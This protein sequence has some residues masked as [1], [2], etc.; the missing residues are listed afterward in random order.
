MGKK[1]IDAKVEGIFADVDLIRSKQIYELK[2][3]P[4]NAKCETLANRIEEA[5][6]FVVKEYDALLAEQETYANREQFDL[7][8]GLL[9]GLV[10]EISNLSKKQP[11]GL[12]NSFKVGQINRVLEPLKDIMK[13]EP[14]TSFLDLVAVVD[15]E[16]KTDKS[17]NTYSD[18]GL[19]L[20]QYL[21]AC[22]IYR[23]KL[24]KQEKETQDNAWSLG[25]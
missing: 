20:S 11:D 25:I 12:L 17:R 14:S 1:E 10:S 7:L 22:K 18:V 21:E 4:G 8:A 9:K 2:K 19:I 13:D 15:P 23:V 16:S 6:G 3:T 24:N 5:I